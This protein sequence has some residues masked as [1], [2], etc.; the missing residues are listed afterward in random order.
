M[1]SGLAR[2]I[3]GRSAAFYAATGAAALLPLASVPY[4]TRTLGPE[5]W[6]ELAIAQAVATVLAVLVDYGH[7]QS[8]TRALTAP[9]RVGSLADDLSERCRCQSAS[10]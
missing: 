4:L 1:A 8:A 6:G 3:A 9:R 7:A 5:A 2:R 10:D